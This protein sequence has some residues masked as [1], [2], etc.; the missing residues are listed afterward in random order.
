M[1]AQISL[2]EDN[3]KQDSQR[4]AFFDQLQSRIEALPGVDAAGFISELPLS[5]QANDTLF[6]IA[7]HPPANAQERNDADFREVAGDYFRAMRM[8]LLAGREFTPADAA[9]NK[10]MIINEPLAKRYFPGESPLGKHLQI[11]G[12][13]GRSVS[14]EIVGIVGG[15]KHFSL[16]ENLRSQMFF[17]YAQATS[18]TMNLTVRSSGKT[19][20]LAAAVRG[21]LQDMDPEQAVSAFRAMNDV[22]SAT[23]AGSRF[24]AILLGA[25]GGIALL[26]TATGIFGVLSYLVTQ[27]T[28]EIG[29][30]VALGA[31]PQDVLRVIVGHGMRLALMGV[32]IGLAGALAATRWMSSFL[33]SV[34]PTD[35]LTFAAVVFLLAATAFLACYLPAHRAMRVD[36]MVALRYE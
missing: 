7:E 6:T 21:I 32:V 35:P 28:R 27:R 9:S 24:N 29:V 30:R 15:V 3:Y 19:L 36:P 14:W 10:V 16:Q 11:L 2:V 34:K 4:A 13:D 33:F 23:T 5:G 17:P 25:F 26:L 18:T 1:T 8:P 12:G 20:G 22:V 31:Q